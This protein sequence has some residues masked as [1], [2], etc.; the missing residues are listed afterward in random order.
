MSDHYPE[1]PDQHSSHDGTCICPQLR[2]CEERV[3]DD[4][5]GAIRDGSQYRS[6]F[7]AGL[8]AARESVAASDPY[9]KVDDGETGDVFVMSVTAALAAIDALRGTDD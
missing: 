8:D 1:C 5:W 4:I 7:E 2:A 9:W 3:A 6:G